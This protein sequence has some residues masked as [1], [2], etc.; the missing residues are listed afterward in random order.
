MNDTIAK[1]VDDMV[2]K[3][4]ADIMA[5]GQL[6]WRYTD[7]RMITFYQHHWVMS[8]IEISIECGKKTE[9]RGKAYRSASSNEVSLAIPKLY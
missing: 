8:M 6:D 4:V 7:F 1:G 2:L 5:R 9:K 3:V